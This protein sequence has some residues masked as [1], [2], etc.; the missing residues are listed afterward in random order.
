MSL[1]DR[2][3]ACSFVVL[4]PP[5]AMRAELSA[6]DQ[7]VADASDE[8]LTVLTDNH[9]FIFPP[10]FHFFPNPSHIFPRPLLN[11]KP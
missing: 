8:D 6:L 7:V 4:G 9:E 5:S 10:I 3:P 1:G 2:L 11:P